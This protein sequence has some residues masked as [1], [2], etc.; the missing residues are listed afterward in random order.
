MGRPVGR[1]AFQGRLS[2]LRLVSL[3]P[4]ASCGGVLRRH[5]VGEAVDSASRGS[6]GTFESVG[7]N[8]LRRLLAIA[9]VACAL[10]AAACVPQDR[11]TVGEVG[12]GDSATGPPVFPE[13]GEVP[14][15]LLTEG[16]VYDFTNADADLDLWVPP[17]AEAQ[18]AADKIVENHG[19]RLSDVGYEPG[20]TGAALNDVAL[21][22]EERQSI[23]AL[24]RSCINTVEMLASLFIGGGH[25][26][27]E[28][29]L[30]MAKGLDSEGVS[31]A[32]IENWVV[33]AGFD[34]LADDGA[35]AR[36]ML[37]YTDVCLPETSFTWNGFELPGDAEVQG[38]EGA[39]GSDEDLPGSVGNETTTTLGGGSGG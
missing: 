17:R 11:D 8:R 30:C 10:V 31:A 3:R 27:P 1:G 19:K 34:P 32:I 12:G 35:F 2:L 36:S 9:A 24:F 6:T 13:T 28:Q 4:E 26:T 23:A 29:A 22:P 39:E 7:T 5:S 15:E 20:R 18:C 25:M 16:L 37:A 14:P 21:R 38:A 33:G